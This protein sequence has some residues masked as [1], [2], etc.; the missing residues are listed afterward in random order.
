MS[1]QY[2]K[3][4]DNFPSEV[5]GAIKLQ[6]AFICS[7]PDCKKSTVAPSLTNDLKIQYIGKVAHICAAAANGPRFCTDMSADERMSIY[8]AIFLCS[9]CADMIDKNNGRDYDSQLLHSWKKE[10]HQWVL[11][12]LNNDILSASISVS[13]QF[14]SGGITANTV[15]ISSTIPIQDDKKLHD[16]QIFLRSDEIFNDKVMHRLFESLDGYGECF[17]NDKD[18]LFY[19][20]DFYQKPSNGYLNQMVETQMKKFIIKAETLSNFINI[21]NF[22]KW[23]YDQVG[24]NYRV[25]LHPEYLRDTRYRKRNPGD[26]EK[27]QE[28]YLQLKRKLNALKKQYGIF[29]KV[30][31]AELYL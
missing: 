26:A 31:K 24:S 5:I 15:N 13:S 17:S 2:V 19:I 29:R 22:D 6:S 7:N 16:Q 28:L 23:P 8:N 4:R 14:Q 20:C 30:I 10:H 9:N 12:N 21:S 3:T 27:W 11:S 25:Q 1:K 18:A